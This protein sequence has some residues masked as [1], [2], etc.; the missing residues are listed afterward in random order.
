MFA[1]KRTGSH[2]HDCTKAA[3]YSMTEHAL[4][5]YGEVQRRTRS[6]EYDFCEAQGLLQCVSQFLG[7]VK[8]NLDLMWTCALASI[9]VR[10]NSFTCLSAV[11]LAREKNLLSVGRLP[12]ALG[13]FTLIPGP[14]CNVSSSKRDIRDAEAPFNTQ[15]WLPMS[16]ISLELFLLH[17]CR[18]VQ[19]GRR[20]IREHNLNNVF[21][22]QE[23]ALCDM[24][25]VNGRTFKEV[26]CVRTISRVYPQASR[27]GLEKWRQSRSAQ[28]R[29]LEGP[30]PLAQLE[31]DEEPAGSGS[32]PETSCFPTRLCR[33]GL[34]P[35]F[36]PRPTG[37]GV[38]SKTPSQATSAK[39]R[40]AAAYMSQRACSYLTGTLS[41]LGPPITHR[42]AGTTRHALISTSSS[43]RKL[44]GS[45]TRG[46]TRASAPP[47]SRIGR[48]PIARWAQGQCELSQDH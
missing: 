21:G 1:V 3:L 44:T 48:R 17:A 33:P 18:D 22:K 13:H 7:V 36:Q 5:Q 46:F 11:G 32:E 34:T 20:V 4:G 6:H 10:M 37:Q 23:R 38:R 15:A 39:V 24:Y 26:A 43:G 2:S 27:S 45:H 14:T 47:R 35:P 28:S 41:L 19:A 9:G 16:Y 25:V 29:G 42:P 8:S 12:M 30:S 40:P 31:P